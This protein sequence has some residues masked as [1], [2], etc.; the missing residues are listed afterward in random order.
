[1]SRH[2]AVRF[3]IASSRTL[4]NFISVGSAIRQ[5]GKECAACQSDRDR[6]DDDGSDFD[7]SE[8]SGLMLLN[9]DEAV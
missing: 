5:A 4:T 1:M 9:G 2:R 8:K 7:E 6:D 3:L